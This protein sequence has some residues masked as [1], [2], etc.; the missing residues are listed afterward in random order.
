MAS[1]LS[2]SGGGAGMGGLNQERTPAAGRP[3]HWRRLGSRPQQG[4]RYV[5]G[6]Q[7]SAEAGEQDW[8]ARNGLLKRKQQGTG[9]LGMRWWRQTR[10]RPPR[11][12]SIEEEGQPLAGME[13]SSGSHLPEVRQC[14]LFGWGAGPFEAGPV[15]G[16]SGRGIRCAGFP[17]DRALDAGRNQ[18]AVQR[19]QREQQEA[20]RRRLARWRQQAGAVKQIPLDCGARPPACG[21]PAP[22]DVH[23][24]AALMSLVWGALRADPGRIRNVGN[25]IASCLSDSESRSRKVSE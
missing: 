23:G 21:S 22:A 14:G 4:V 6:V 1:P 18:G 10:R 3:P 11:D 5:G 13:A 19:N 16:R 2:E 7:G 24:S 20:G 25:Q 12:R 9:R 15:R 17:R 8:K